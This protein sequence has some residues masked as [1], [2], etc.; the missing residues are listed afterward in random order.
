MTKALREHLE[1]LARILSWNDYTLVVPQ[2]NDECKSI[3]VKFENVFGQERSMYME[4]GELESFC[5]ALTD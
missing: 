1:G 5:E 2:E 4:L 3:Q